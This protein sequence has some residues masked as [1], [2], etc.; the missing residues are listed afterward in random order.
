MEYKITEKGELYNKKGRLI[1]PRVT[2]SGY[3]KY[4]IYIEG[5]YR[6]I[7]AHRLVAETFIPNPNNKPCV[8]HKDGNKHNNCIDNL[9]WCTYKE[10]A[11]HSYHVLG[12]KVNSNINGNLNGELNGRAKLTKEIVEEIRSLVRVRGEKVWER[13]DISKT[14][15]YNIINRRNWQ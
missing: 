9:E 15:Y 6:N 7:L 1:K 12:K 2:N 14:M 10:N 8:N 3:L 4:Y 13:Y 5:V 11:L